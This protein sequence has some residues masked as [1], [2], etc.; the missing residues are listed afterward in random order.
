MRS[1]A[2]GIYAD[3][4][5]AHPPAFRTGDCGKLN[6]GICLADISKLSLR[7]FKVDICI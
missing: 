1:A 5:I 7:Q 4:R 6:I 3:F 2:S